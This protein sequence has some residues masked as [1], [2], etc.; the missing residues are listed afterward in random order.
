MT[1]GEQIKN[2]RKNAGMTQSELARKMNIPY[3]S[4]GQ[5]ETGRR[6]PKRETLEKISHVLGIGPY[7]LIPPQ[8]KDSYIEQELGEISAETI[9][10]LQK[11]LSDRL[12]TAYSSLD[13]FGRV[14]A[15]KI[16]ELLSKSDA[17][18]GHNKTEALKLAAESVQCGNILVTQVKNILFA[19]AFDGKVF[20]ELINSLLSKEDGSAVSKDEAKIFLNDSDV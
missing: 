20:L 12:A 17:Y 19:K 8:E 10:H 5:W 9:D 15:V 11:N 1:I 2:A 14:T 13:F 16:M 4:I 18:C 3:Q 6:I 7:D